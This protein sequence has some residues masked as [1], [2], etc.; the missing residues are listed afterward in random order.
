MGIQIPFVLL[1]FLAPALSHA[2]AFPKPLTLSFYQTDKGS[3]TLSESSETSPAGDD[4][5]SPHKDDPSYLAHVKFGSSE[6][7]SRKFFWER[8]GE[9]DPISVC[10]DRYCHL[11]Y[12]VLTWI[13]YR[14]GIW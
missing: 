1:V 10:S 5:V 11:K 12:T 9:E 6:D 4:G 7:S 13:V 8:E 2:A 14:F 3:S